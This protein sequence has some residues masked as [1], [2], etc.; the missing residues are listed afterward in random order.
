MQNDKALDRP[1]LGAFYNNGALTQLTLRRVAE[2]RHLS[3]QALATDPA[4]PVFLMTAGFIAD[5][6]GHTQEAADDDAAALRSDP[7]N[8]SAA[9]DLGVELARMHEDD[10][11][12]AALRKAVGARQSYALGWFNLGVLY[13]RMGPRHLLA[14]QGALARALALDPTMRDRQRRLA[15]DQSVYE[16]HLDLSKP[17]PPHWSLAQVQTQAPAA[18]AG[19]LAACTLA[20][21]LARKATS[22]D[23]RSVIG[24]VV[25][26]VT[27]WLERLPPLQRLSHLGW[28]LAATTLAFVLA[29]AHGLAGRTTEVLGYGVGVLLVACLAVRARSVVARRRGRTATQAA[30]GPGLVFGVATGAAGLPWAPLPAVSSSPDDASVHWTAPAAL[31]LLGLPLLFE[32]ALLDV[33]LTR[34]LA[35]ATVIMAASVLTPVGPLDGKRIGTGKA[36]AG[37]GVLGAAALLALGVV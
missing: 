25:E 5:R 16:T 31:A 37:A 28:A 13:D 32:A 14:S 18:A 12:V 10:R 22:G 30:W 20:L 3:G 24:K 21:G 8:F 1:R 15:I 11:A 26:P 7:G 6:A 36:L 34:L 33:P 23:A 4:N 35:V 17:V 27:G 2:A 29:E 9:N 19:L